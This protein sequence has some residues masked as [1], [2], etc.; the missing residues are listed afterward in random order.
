MNSKKH[1][2]RTKIYTRTGD[3]GETSLID[4]SRVQKSNNRVETYG[5]V[6]E[7]NATIGVVR[8]LLSDTEFDKWLFDIQKCLFT[9]GSILATPEGSD[10]PGRIQIPTEESLEKLIDRCDEEIPQLKHFILPGGTSAAA[11]LHLARTI[12]R[13][14]ERRLVNLLTHEN[15]NPLVLRYLNR[16]ADLLF[17]LARLENHRQGVKEIHWI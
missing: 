15:V 3:K 13:R 10:F 4:G 11:M 9:I 16:L 5:T 8:S 14:A 12:C 1:N 17:S 6:D 2:S 7:L